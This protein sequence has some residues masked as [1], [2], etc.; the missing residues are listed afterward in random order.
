MTSVVSVVVATGVVVVTV[1]DSVVEG[2]GVVVCTDVED[3]VV[4]E[5]NEEDC[6]R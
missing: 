6:I 2:T 3:V 5:T 4:S 1:V